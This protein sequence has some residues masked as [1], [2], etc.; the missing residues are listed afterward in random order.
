MKMIMMVMMM[1]ATHHDEKGHV[2]RV[3]PEL[4]LNKTTMG[5]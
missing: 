5:R 1:C 4:H 3:G 2:V